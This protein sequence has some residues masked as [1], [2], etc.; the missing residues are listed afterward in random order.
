MSKTKKPKSSFN[1]F[2]R[3][4]GLMKIKTAKKLSTILHIHYTQCVIAGVKKDFNAKSALD[5]LLT[6]REWW[7]EEFI[8][9]VNRGYDDL[10]ISN[11]PRF[12]EEEK[13]K[14]TR[15]A[16]IQIGGDDVKGDDEDEIPF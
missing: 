15:L 8:K 2:L 10:H 14:W 12:K 7:E 4:F 6:A 13:K 11:P 1:R 16:N 9:M 5:A 3:V